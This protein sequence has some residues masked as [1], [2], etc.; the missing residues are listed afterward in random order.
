MRQ[1]NLLI[2]RLRGLFR[3]EAV[4][5]DIEEEMR[6]HVE[7]ETQTNIERGMEP[8]KARV[9]ALRA[10]GNL[11]LVKDVAYDVRG[12]GMLEALW[13][14]VRH[15][16]R[17][18][19]EKPGFA[20]VAVTTLGLGIGA[21]TAIFTFLN[22]ILLRPLPYPDP[23]RLVILWERSPASTDNLMV[24]PLNFI[25]WRDR[26]QSFEALALTQSIPVTAMMQE[27]AEQVS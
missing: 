17:T 21:N 12:G 23:D 6:L 4:L 16:A 5:E 1:L 26:A 8:E 3:R 27:G 20:V 13:L 14:D 24:L 25:E 19:R 18:L 11:G 9:A 10:F 15:A 7:M 22:S 2:A